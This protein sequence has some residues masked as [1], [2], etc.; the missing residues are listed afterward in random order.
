MATHSSVLAWRIPGTVGCC[1]W[2]HT[3]SD[4]T[5]VT[6]QQQQHASIYQSFLLATGIEEGRDL[7]FNMPFR[8]VQSFCFFFPRTTYLWI[9][10]HFVQL[11]E[12]SCFKFGLSTPVWSSDIQSVRSLG[13]IFFGCIFLETPPPRALEQP[14]LCLAEFPLTAIQSPPSPPKLCL[15]LLLLLILDFLQLYLSDPL[16]TSVHTTLLNLVARK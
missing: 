9:E 14:S 5:E 1:L 8:A 13:A 7:F 10:F 2:G 11:G 16:L 15:N 4:M 6:Q 3:E 12:K